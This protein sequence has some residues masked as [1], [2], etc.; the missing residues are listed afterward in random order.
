MAKVDEKSRKRM[1]VEE[2]ETPSPKVETPVVPL[3]VVQTT[4]EPEVVATPEPKPVSENV[5]TLDSEFPESVEKTQDPVITTDTPVVDV[6]GPEVKEKSAPAEEDKVVASGDPIAQPSTNVADDFI[7]LDKNSSGPKPLLILI[8]GV[9]LLGALLGGIV[10]YRSSVNTQK[11]AEETPVPTETTD[12]T[13][14]TSSPSATLDLSKYT[15]DILNGSGIAG[16]AG[17]VKT[18]L[19]DAEF[20][21]GTAGNAAT[22]DYTKTVVKA[23]STVDAAFVTK[24]IETLGKTYI[25]DKAQTL[26]TSSS[27]DVQVVVGTSKK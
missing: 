15:V 22:Y 6:P 5:H 24:L 9:L 10:F 17:K 19:T 7:P 11:S 16:E 2:V 8:P 18:I 20:K 12:V 27:N 4:P 23:K 21:V 13:T 25:V 3:E 26:S 1:V 14:P